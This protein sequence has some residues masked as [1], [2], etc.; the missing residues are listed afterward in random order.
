MTSERRSLL[1][2]AGLLLL[3]AFPT[4]ASSAPLHPAC[5]P[6]H[7]SHASSLTVGPR[8]LCLTDS[9]V[10]GKYELWSVLPPT[11]APVRLSP[12]LAADRDV[13]LFVASPDGQRVAFTADPVSWTKYELHTVAIGGGAVKK[14]NGQLPHEHDVDD[15]AWSPGSQFVVYRQGRNT[16]GYW[17]LYS[18]AAV[19]GGASRLSPDMA[20]GGAVQRGFQILADSRV[21]YSANVDGGATF[22]WY[23]VPVSA[24]P[25]LQELFADGF[26]SAGTGAWR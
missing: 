4:P 9:V 6:A 5:P 25:T 11:G 20:V 24:G 8:V 12:D 10:A 18:S 16:T 15:F 22:A 19:G 2:V 14:L 3:S 26:E 7:G 13:I 1:A 21:R 17:H 23:V